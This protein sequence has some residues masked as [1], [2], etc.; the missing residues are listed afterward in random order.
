LHVLQL[1]LFL[2]GNEKFTGE[3]TLDNFAEKWLR[4]AVQLEE[5]ADC[6]ISAGF[7]WDTSLGTDVVSS[8]SCTDQR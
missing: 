8:K 6:D 4:E 7:A 3:I 1:S 5:M 2:R